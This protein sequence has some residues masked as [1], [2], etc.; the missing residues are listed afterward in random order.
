M[1]SKS[2]F[3]IFA[4]A[5][6]FLLYRFYLQVSMDCRICRVPE[7]VKHQSHCFWL[8]SVN[9]VQIW[10]AD[11]SP[12]LYS[13]RLNWLHDDFPWRKKSTTNYAIPQQTIYFYNKVREIYNS[14]IS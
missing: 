13:V 9:Y 1:S 2:F 11:C 8:E 6:D 10:V 14:M 7:G 3:V 5:L 12:Q 4:A